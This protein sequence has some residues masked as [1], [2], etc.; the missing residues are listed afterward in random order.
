MDLKRIIP[1][2][3]ILAVFVWGGIKIKKGFTHL[4]KTDVVTHAD[5][6]AS[7][8]MGL[9]RMGFGQYLR[10]GKTFGNEIIQSGITTECEPYVTAIETLDLASYKDSSFRVSYQQL[11]D[12]NTNCSITDE[13]VVASEKNYLTKCLSN[14]P[15]KTD[16]LTEACVQSVFSLRSAMTRVLEKNKKLSEIDSLAKLTDLVYSDV[17]TA[18]NGGADTDPLDLKRVEAIA[19]QMSNLDSNF[20]GAK[21]LKVYVLAQNAI[22]QSPSKTLK[23]Q[24]EIWARVGHELDSLK[25]AGG[26][27]DGIEGLDAAIQTRGFDPTLTLKYASELLVKTPTSGWGMFLQA[28]GHWKNDDHEDAFKELQKAVELDPKDEIYQRVLS[29][30]SRPGAGE[31]AFWPALKF[32]LVPQ[33][34]D[35]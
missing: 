7:L 16:T 5:L 34:F 32:N 17:F 13:R 10:T 24:E 3:C 30:I 1:L 6:V 19:E 22:H 8:P 18:A 25:L 31:E 27:E 11:P 23:E 12:P 15:T 28:Y 35:K 9:T 26:G 14:N 33:D 4:M 20:R 2:C 29:Q 21:R